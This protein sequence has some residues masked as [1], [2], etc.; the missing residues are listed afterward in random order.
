[1]KSVL[2]EVLDRK[3]DDIQQENINSTE[4]QLGKHYRGCAVGFWRLSRSS[5]G[6]EER[7]F[8][9]EETA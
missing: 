4:V 1:M 7:A 5:L 3:N 9:A 6:R 2:I 8:L